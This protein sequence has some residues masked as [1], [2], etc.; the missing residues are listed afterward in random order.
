MFIFLPPLPRKHLA[1]IGC[2]EFGQ[3]AQP[4]GVTVH[5]HIVGSF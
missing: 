5:S 4:I 3:I 2:T 1:A